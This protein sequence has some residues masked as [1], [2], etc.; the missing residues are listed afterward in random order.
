MPGKQGGI[1]SWVGSCS[2]TGTRPIWGTC[3]GPVPACLL[4]AARQDL[5]TPCLNFD[6]YH[7]DLEYCRRTVE[8]LG[9]DRLIAM[10]DHTERDL[11]AEENLRR[12]EGVVWLRSDGRVAAGS[13]GY[14][15]HRN[16]MIKIDLTTED[17]DRMFLS[18]P[19]AAAMFV[20]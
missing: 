18:T 4:S 15:W 11:L 20:P 6:G 13:V 19:R 8:F 9:S 12:D 5:L 10:T 7:V 16:R 3:L 1:K 14:E 17:I 2:P